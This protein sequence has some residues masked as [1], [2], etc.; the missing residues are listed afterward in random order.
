MHTAAFDPPRRDLSPVSTPLASTRGFTL[1]ELL[2]VIAIVGVLLALLL[3]AAQAAR[4]SARAL[5]CKNRMRQLVIATQLHHETLGYYPPA[6]YQMRPDEALNTACG[7]QSPTWLVRVMPYMEEA[8]FAEQWDLATS[9]KEHPER[10]RNAVPDGFLCP[11]RRAGTQPVGS[12]SEQGFEFVNGGSLPCGCPLPPKKQV[13]ETIYT[14][15]LSDYAGNH[16]DLSPG[17]IGEPSDYYW[18]GNGS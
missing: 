7:D 3:P 15:A 16:G 18:G 5:D 1:V 9:W 8:R 2:V 10:V 17:A 6:R 13:T 12:V 4:E 14:G 11:T